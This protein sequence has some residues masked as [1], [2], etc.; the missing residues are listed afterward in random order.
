MYGSWARCGD[1][2]LLRMRDMMARVRLAVDS[3]ND[4]RSQSGLRHFE[5]AL[6]RPFPI[7][8][9]ADARSI[10]RAPDVFQRARSVATFNYTSVTEKLWNAWLAERHEL[11]KLRD[12]TLW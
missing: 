11:P 12:A 6:R 1:V 10:D 7:Y 9:K 5:R 4:N 8:W 2:E 3:S